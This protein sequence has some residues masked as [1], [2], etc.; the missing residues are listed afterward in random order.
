ML[1]TRRQAGV[2]L[3]CHIICHGRR[4][5]VTLSPAHT[6]THRMRTTAHK[7]SPWALSKQERWSGHGSIYERAKQP[8][9]PLASTSLQLA[10]SPAKP[11]LRTRPCEKPSTDAVRELQAY[12]AQGE[13][14]LNTMRAMLLEMTR[15]ATLLCPPTPHDA[16]ATSD[17]IEVILA[18]VPPVGLGAAAQVSSAWRDASDVVRERL[19]PTLAPLVVRPLMA[20][21][22]NFRSLMIA[23]AVCTTWRTAACAE[24]NEWRRAIEREAWE[25]ADGPMGRELSV[26][27]FVDKVL[28]IN[29]RMGT[30]VVSNGGLVASVQKT[31]VRLGLWPMLGEVE[32]RE[33]MDPPDMTLVARPDPHDEP[34][35]YIVAGLE[36]VTPR[37]RELV[38]ILAVALLVVL[39]NEEEEEERAW[40]ATGAFVPGG[41]ED[42][43]ALVEIVGGFGFE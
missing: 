20:S 30:E 16:V 25:R 39:S 10:P 28:R 17:P 32:V 42:A 24:R 2:N 8:S 12:I 23:S 37:I 43:R 19:E 40:H 3:A 35:A 7:M 9:T 11:L 4:Q 13:A 14:H 6:D 38:D 15:D 31:L 5:R 34:N 27:P 36:R 29:R 22:P 41:D 26:V 33:L 1:A 18:H 21:M